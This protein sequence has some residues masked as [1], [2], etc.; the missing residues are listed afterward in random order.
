M[1]IEYTFDEELHLCRDLK[2]NII[3]TVSQCMAFA[4]ISF[5]FK[6]FVDPEV[7]DFR[8]ALGT[9]VHKLTDYHD[10]FGAV[11]DSWLNQDNAGYLESWVGLKRISGIKPIR[12]S[13]RRTELV[14]GLPVSGET[15]KEMLLNGHPCIIDLKTGSAKSDSWGV[16][17]AGYEQIKY[18]STRIGREIRAVAWLKRDGSPAQLIEYGERSPVDGDHYGERFLMALSE[19]HYRLR[20]GLLT[21]YDFLPHP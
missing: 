4:G 19:T 15:D 11:D 2:G 3:P 1:A 7:L 8:S 17:L 6:R 9:E 20:R 5:D 18:R 10:E 14:N 13:T 21:E 12:W 16:Q